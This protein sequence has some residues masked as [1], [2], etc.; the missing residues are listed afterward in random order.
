[1]T[2]A[3][4]EE[5][6]CRCGGCRWLQ[7]P[8]TR[9][10]RQQLIRGIGPQGPGLHG[11]LK[12]EGGSTGA[13]NGISFLQASVECDWCG[14]V[15]NCLGRGVAFSAVK[16]AIGITV[17]DANDLIHSGATAR[18]IRLKPRPWKRF[19]NITR[20]G[21]CFIK[22]KSRVFECRDFTQWLR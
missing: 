11:L 6:P 21:A 5:V 9:R 4:S 3:R 16:S 1:M 7:A 18:V 19:V 15:R 2:C 22:A 13:A 14:G 10:R 12:F 8:S 20:D 17:E